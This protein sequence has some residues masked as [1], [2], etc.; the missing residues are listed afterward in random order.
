MYEKSV[1]FT[2]FSVSPHPI[3]QASPLAKDKKRKRKRKGQWG[4]EWRFLPQ[5][6]LPNTKKSTPDIIYIANGSRCSR[7]LTIFAI[8]Y[9]RKLAKLLDVEVDDPMRLEAVSGQR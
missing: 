9:T 6:R 3:P 1:F 7:K 5:K 4:R 2:Y 8:V